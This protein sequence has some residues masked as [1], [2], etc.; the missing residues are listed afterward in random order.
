MTATQVS[1]GAA[2]RLRERRA[3]LRAIE[4]ALVEARAEE[5]QLLLV[6]GAAGVGKTALLRAAIAAATK[7][8][9]LVLGARG[10][11]LE[12]GFAFGVVGQL[13]AA[14]VHDAR[15][16]GSAEDLLAGDARLAEL[17]LSPAPGS[18][19]RDADF[20]LLNA[21]YWLCGN[22]CER[23]PVLLVVDDAH[24]AD[25][26]SLRFLSFLARR[27]DG[28]ALALAVAARPGEPGVGTDPF[29]ELG[30]EDR[31][32]WIEPGLLSAAAVSGLVREQL[33]EGASD[34]LCRA[35]HES[36]RGNAFL[37]EQVIVGLRQ[38]GKPLMEI[39][40][41]D[42]D[43]VAAEGIS[44]GVMGRIAPLGPAAHALAEATAVLGAR[45][46]PRHAAALAKLE[47][48]RAEHVADGLRRAGILAPGRVLEFV[49]PLIRTSIYD[50]IPVGE[51]GSAH[52]TAA[53]LLAAEDADPGAVASHLLH[54]PRHGDA[55]A[56]VQLQTAATASLAQGA[57]DR[58]VDYLRRA[59]QEPPTPEKRPMILF[60]LG[61]AEANANDPAAADT[62]DRARRLTTDPTLKRGV[63]LSMGGVLIAAGQHA[64]LMDLIDEE[65]D[66]LGDDDTGLTAVFETFMLATIL[67]SPPDR[68]LSERTQ[69][70]RR[71]GIVDGLPPE[72][73]RMRLAV[74]SRCELNFGGRAA[75]AV[76][77]ADRSLADGLLIREHLAFS[78]LPF[79]ALGTLTFV[80][81]LHRAERYHDDSI[82]LAREG[83]LT[84]ALA[85]SLTGRAVARK[86]MGKLDDAEADLMLALRL[87]AELP[88]SLTEP[89]ARAVLCEIRLDR[90]DLDAAREAITLD[91]ERYEGTVGFRFL[92]A[93]RARLHL[94]L[95]KPAEAL[96]ELSELGDRRVDE[97][98][99]RA[100][101]APHWPP[102]AVRALLATEQRDEALSVAEK[103]VSM[104]RAF[105]APA[106]TSA[107]LVG[108]GLCQDDRDQAI[109]LLEEAVG[110]A[111]RSESRVALLAA[112]VELGGA[113]RRA[114]HRAAAREPLRAAIDLA[115]RTGAAAFGD[116]AR[117]ELRATGARPRRQR[118]S[119][120]ASL[121]A[122]ERRIA[123]LA[124]E[125]RTNRQIAQELFVTIKTVEMHL[126]NA[127][128]KLDIASR[129][130]L[131][132]AL[133][134]G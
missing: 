73:A 90:G 80:G 36:T 71:V 27:G 65:L 96:R 133:S 20:A 25:A 104:A 46:E 4:A 24:W 12:Q 18:P 122:S 116:R 84:R 77:L 40:V 72:I 13:F 121:T 68:P 79:L 75:V 83:H 59:L 111:Q 19:P 115:D 42:I 14:I 26:A 41:G 67:A 89:V 70:I 33:W 43:G 91:L 17:A 128:H 3:E 52:A 88:M 31:V 114:G 98:G 35:C 105:G 47:P 21:L 8:G 118:L 123:Q 125:G 45:A 129:G 69:G 2:P 81:E 61:A 92:R 86:Q 55:E 78:A 50:A 22:L 82:A 10:G 100:E 130:E 66:Q 132:A 1:D 101:L 119:G 126:S 51:R 32:R 95:G 54:A 117:D 94:A 48:D 87:D 124:V 7:S 39:A 76:N 5:G 120:P 34:E 60:A 53:E 29:A 107:A 134:E 131:N 37:V 113:Q 15:E 38:A 108:L 6:S 109:G 62:L 44:A 106:T 64:D 57:A 74:L 56:V 102:L 97:L 11:E 127:Y 58:A 63:L 30:L 49:H 93:A 23:S 9:F 16:Q 110:E 112:L 103:D 99:S 85:T 28:M